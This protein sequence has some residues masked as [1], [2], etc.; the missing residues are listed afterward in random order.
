MLLRSEVWTLNG[1]GNLTAVESMPDFDPKLGV[2]VS[3]NDI[4]VT[5]LGTR[6]SVTYFKRRG[7]PLVGHLSCARTIAACCTGLSLV[8]FLSLGPKIIPVISSLHLGPKENGTTLQKI[9]PRSAASDLVWAQLVPQ[10][11]FRPKSL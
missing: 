6:Y 10:G 8:P 5:L 3:G 7:S 9:G 1:A 2:L 11:T 4:I